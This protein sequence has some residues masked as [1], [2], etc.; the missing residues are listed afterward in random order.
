MRVMVAMSGGVDSS[1]AAAMMVDAGHEVLGVT[2]KLRETSA[3]ERAGRSASCC[4]P[5]DLLDARQVCDT[6]G[7]AHYVVDYRD[8][9]RQTVIEPFAESYLRGE[10]PNPCVRCN[11]HVKFA[12]LLDRAEALGADYL[13]TG[14]Y[15]QIRPGPDGRG[16]LCRGVDARKDQSYF[17][18]G[19]RRE[20]IDRLRFPL[21]TLSK[22]E[23]RARAQRMGLPTWDKA[24][25]EDI[26]FVPGGDYTRVVERIAGPGR[27]PAAG[28]IRHLDGRTLGEHHGV[29]HF[30]VGQRKGL[31]VAGGERLY[32]VNVDAAE[33][34]VRVGPRDALLAHALRATG[35]HWIDAPPAP[36]QRVRVQIRYRHTGADAEIFAD[37]DRALIRFTEPQS[38]I[39]PGQ[40]AVVYAGDQV[41]GGGWIERVGPV[42]LDEARAARHGG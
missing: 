30:T 29:H 17:L 25:S 39:A 38:A 8:V 2:M 15:A 18:F 41:L 14:H 40:A 1:V 6:L 3:E 23:V 24:D 36:G 28:E 42:V 21:G 11:D 16:M 9:F 19:L 35:C 20:A 33:N 26:C 27:L 4:S 13:V 37:G 7:I 12:P 31:G 32:V 22:D 10:T 34:V 5:D